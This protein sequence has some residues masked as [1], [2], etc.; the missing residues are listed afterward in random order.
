M[1]NDEASRPVVSYYVR[2]TTPKSYTR[3]IDQE[4]APKTPLASMP[5]S[6]IGDSR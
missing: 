5:F 6:T 2:E 3:S 4:A 1:H